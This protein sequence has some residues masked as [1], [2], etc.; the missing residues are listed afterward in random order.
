MFYWPEVV[1]LSTARA[2]PSVQRSLP[3]LGLRS[4]PTLARAAL[5][6][7]ER[8]LAAAARPY[9]T[10]RRQRRRR[11]SPLPP[12]DKAHRVDKPEAGASGGEGGGGEGESWWQSTERQAHITQ[13]E[14]RV[15]IIAVVSCTAAIAMFSWNKREVED[16]LQKLPPDVQRAWREGNYTPAQTAGVGEDSSARQ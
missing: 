15:A 8:G 3:M 14:R 16:R 10:T 9:A 1:L 6:L 12:S 13:A 7:S 5:P 4:L 2:V 11:G